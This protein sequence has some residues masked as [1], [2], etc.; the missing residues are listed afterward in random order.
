MDYDD[1]KKER[2]I[3]LGSG[4]SG[5][6]CAKLLLSLSK[7]V[8]LFNSEEETDLNKIKEKFD[9]F[10][11][12]DFKKGI[13]TEDDLKDIGLCVISPGINP[14]KEFVK[15]I[16]NCDIPICSE[17]EI[18]YHFAKGNICG[19]TGTNGKTTTTAILGEILKEKYDDVYVCGNIGKAFS[20]D[21]LKTNDNSYIA[22]EISSF[23]L[24]NII[25][26]KPSVACITN[27][28]PDH[29]DRYKTYEN[30][31]NSK[32][33][34]SLNQ[35]EYD[36]IVLNYD[37]EILKSLAEEKI[38]KAKVVF[39]SSTNE[40]ANGFYYKN[41]YIYYKENAKAK[42]L[43]NVSEIHLM[44]KHNY[45]NIMA[46]MAV[47]YYMGVDF[48]TII[49]ACKKFQP[50]EHRIEF[51]RERSGVKYYND[52]KA[53]NPDSAIK[54]LLSMKGK[55]V[56]IAGGYNKNS[57]YTD[58]VKLFNGR[59]SKLILIG[60]TK[61]DIAKVCRLLKFNEIMYADTLKEAVKFASSFAN[62]GDNVLLSPGCA[63]WGMF[64]NYEERGILFKKEVMNL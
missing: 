6:S 2:T 27:L 55:T 37:D 39:F 33:R 59:V 50:V 47:A 30:Y 23:Q 51:V 9:D 44:G 29:L 56:L 54:G 32:L 7:K 14:N 52:S 18:A 17:I 38:F 26:F 3:I 1:I 25:D 42:E 31:I 10:R 5:I 21:A 8:L 48:N 43:L 35:T 4:K 19:I 24:D 41:G 53:T 11:N 12:I 22:L 63:S 49:S 15:L 16:E 13:L 20:S 36:V 62:I 40:L 34:I 60:D 46:A 45:E 28:S 61:K 64:K 58:W 57:N